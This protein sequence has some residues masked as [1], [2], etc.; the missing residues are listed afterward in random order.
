MKNVIKVF[1]VIVCLFVLAAP[2]LLHAREIQTLKDFKLPHK[3]G[4][5]YTTAL[6]KRTTDVHWVM[7]IT[8]LGNSGKVHVVLV[9]SNYQNRSEVVVMGVERKEIKSTATVSH[10]YH[11]CLQNDKSTSLLKG[12]VFGS[13]SPDK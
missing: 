5:V 10:F 13:W 3:K 2:G 6:Y 11:A 7:N 8:S 1:V 12:C 9:N 4:K